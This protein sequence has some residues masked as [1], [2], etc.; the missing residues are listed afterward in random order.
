MDALREDVDAYVS[1]NIPSVNPRHDAAWFALRAHISILLLCA[2]AWA[3]RGGCTEFWGVCID[4]WLAMAAIDVLGVAAVSVAVKYASAS[5]YAYQAAMHRDAVYGVVLAWRSVAAVLW[6]LASACVWLPSSPA[7]VVRVST[8]VY[9][10]RVTSLVQQLYYSKAC[11]QHIWSRYQARVEQAVAMQ[12]VFTHIRDYATNTAFVSRNGSLLRSKSGEER[13][14]P[15][16]RTLTQR[17]RIYRRS[18]FAT[19]RALQNSLR[20]RDVGSSEEAESDAGIMF[21]CVAHRIIEERG[22]GSKSSSSGG[23]R[24]SVRRGEATVDVIDLLDLVPFRLREV[25]RGALGS[26]TVTRRTFQDAVV[27]CFLHRE[28]MWKTIRDYARITSTM[29]ITLSC[30]R[31]IVLVLVAMFVAGMTTEALGTSLVSLTSV[32]LSLSFA[33]GP[34]VCRCFEGFIF[35]FVQHPFECGDWISLG[36]D[37]GGRPTPIAVRRIHL[38]TTELN[39]MD[40][41]VVALQNCSLREK[42]ICNLSRSKRPLLAIPV[43]VH[44]DTPASFANNLEARL[45]QYAVETNDTLR[46]LN[47]T[48]L[49]CTS[50]DDGASYVLKAFIMMPEG[51]WHD[52]DHC[53]VVRESYT[54]C[55]NE[56]CASSRLNAV[57]SLETGGGP[58]QNLG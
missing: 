20:W 25:A 39:M 22:G 19:H 36:D 5:L 11:R 18:W 21:D 42:N 43:R 28:S 14:G 52:M 13:R 40:G 23:R 30:A 24:A 27:S 53:I 29:G 46:V 50:R 9:A 32:V 51:A 7:N 4:S 55:I 47:V 1:R 41:R 12:E 10:V 58:I 3:R 37:D 8:L 17:R 34:T 48:V 6:S 57:M 54:K 31:A 26:S 2:R 44:A 38:L 15:V 45:K 35:V 49:T 56:F 33:F 16:E